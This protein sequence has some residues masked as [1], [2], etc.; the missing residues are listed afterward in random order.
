M[1]NTIRPRAYVENGIVT[2]KALISHPMETGLRKDKKSGKKIPAHFIKDFTAEKNGTAIISGLLGPAVSKNPFIQFTF[3]N[4]K[5]GDKIKIS[6]EDNKGNSD[7]TE[8]EV[9]E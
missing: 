8:V 4:G 9:I 7:S 3:N 6:W 2:V 5:V 1:A